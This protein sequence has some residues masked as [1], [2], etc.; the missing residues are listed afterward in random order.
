MVL[1]IATGEA[2]KHKH[3]RHL[4]IAPSL[5]ILLALAHGTRLPASIPFK[6]PM[7]A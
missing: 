6:V 4:L 1:V 2:F 3:P 7:V 5:S